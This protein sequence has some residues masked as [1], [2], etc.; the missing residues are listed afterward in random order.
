MSSVQME[1]VAR[2]AISYADAEFDFDD[3][4]VV[5]IEETSVETT[6]DPAR[7]LV[8]MELTHSSQEIERMVSEGDPGEAELRRGFLEGPFQVTLVIADGIVESVEW[9]DIDF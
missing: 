6:L 3:Y 8:K 5:S 9:A 4:R 7:Y 1:D 2:V